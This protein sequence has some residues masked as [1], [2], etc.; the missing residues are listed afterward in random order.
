MRTMEIILPCD[1]SIHLINDINI[2]PSLTWLHS[3]LLE[4][5]AFAL[6]SSQ[7]D[8]VVDKTREE[9]IK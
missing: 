3:S 5:F 9:Q 2:W 7:T 8:T 4:I 6:V 1:D